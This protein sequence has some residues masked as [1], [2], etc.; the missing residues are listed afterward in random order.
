MK[1]IADDALEGKRK[2]EIKREALQMAAIADTSLSRNQLAVFIAITAKYWNRETGEA[3]P[4]VRTLAPLCGISKSAAGRALQALADRGY[5]SPVGRR[6]ATIYEVVSRLE[7]D[8][9]SR[10]ERDSTVPRIQGTE[11][12]TE[13]LIEP[14]IRSLRSEEI[15]KEEKEEGVGERALRAREPEER[16]SSPRQ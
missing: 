7:G 11:P 5:L 3:W 4:S 13:P 12:L 15:L 1:R 16:P 14:L 6:G 9:V 2:F 10:L 8:T